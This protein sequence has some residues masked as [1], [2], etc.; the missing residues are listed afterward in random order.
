MLP[1][2]R[3]PIGAMPQRLLVQTTRLDHSGRLSARGLLQALGWTTGHRVEIT[4]TAGV[5]VI[6]SAAT[7][8]HAVDG[9]GQLALPVTARRMCAITPG[10]PVLLAASLPHD[11]L[12]VHPADM[13][14]VLLT[15]WYAATAGERDGT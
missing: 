11:V 2:P 6:G 9:R 12:V 15:D 1:T 7:G 4:V 3:L 14:A 5:V 10:L 13:I 8:L